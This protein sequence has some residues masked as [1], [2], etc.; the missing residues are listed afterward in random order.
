MY[1]FE[2]RAVIAQVGAGYKSEAADECRAQVGNNIAVKVFHHQ[3]VVL[4]R[5]HHQLHASV[6]HDVFAVGDLGKAL[7][8]GA[9]AAQEQSVRQLHDVGLVDGV[10][11]LA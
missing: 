5:I 2:N 1:S 8:H 4:I 6:V 10:D 9:A 3:H 11:F 7:G